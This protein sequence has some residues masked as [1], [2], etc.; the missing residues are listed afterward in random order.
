MSNDD[1]LEV[2]GNVWDSLSTG[3]KLGLLITLFGFVGAAFW[4]GYKVADT[5]SAN[6]IAELRAKHAQELAQAQ[7]AAPAQEFRIGL[8]PPDAGLPTYDDAKISDLSMLDLAVID[9]SHRSKSKALTSIHQTSPFDEHI[10]HRFTWTGF[11]SDVYPS[12]FDSVPYYKLSLRPELDKPYR[13]QRSAYLVG[14]HHEEMAKALVPDQKVT[15]SG[16]LNDSGNL[17]Q[18][19][20]VKIGDKPSGSK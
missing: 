9:E 6:Q 7:T 17:T 5:R 14:D 1:Q 8:V 16:V 4:G 20:F 3:K 19:K 12:M 2:A 10:G 13:F 15:V 18:C 11:V